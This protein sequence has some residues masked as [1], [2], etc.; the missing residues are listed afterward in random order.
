[1]IMGRAGEKPPARFL[2]MAESDLGS[3]AGTAMALSKMFDIFPDSSPVLPK[4]DMEFVV[5]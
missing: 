3:S 5:N 1:M 4:D 2:C